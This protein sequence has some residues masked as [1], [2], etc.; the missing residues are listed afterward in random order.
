MKQISDKAQNRMLLVLAVGCM[1][2]G[3]H[4]MIEAFLMM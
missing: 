1:A 3:I 2:L 4:F